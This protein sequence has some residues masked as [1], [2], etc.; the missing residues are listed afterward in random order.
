MY[1]NIT[2]P[3]VCSM[4]NRERKV[5]KIHMTQTSPEEADDLGWSVSLER[6]QRCL[7]EG[8]LWRFRQ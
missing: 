3:N 5:K 8:M 7:F 1:K 6:H 2:L 4:N